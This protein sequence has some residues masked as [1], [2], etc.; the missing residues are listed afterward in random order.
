MAKYRLSARA[1]DDIAAIADY[2]IKSFGIEQARH[3]RDGFEQSF[4]MLAE[5]PLR[6][7]S[8]SQFA[9]NLRRWEYES[10]VIFYVP[11]EQGVLIVR[12]LHQR[13]D[14]ERKFMTD[15]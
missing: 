6:G 5:R 4:Q 7:R 1:D 13:M 8:A 2:T 3:Y 14:L 11:D 10:Y 12:V 9:P 15:F